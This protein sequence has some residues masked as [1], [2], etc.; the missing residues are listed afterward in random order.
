MFGVQLDSDGK[1]LTLA[2][3]RY[4][5]RCPDIQH[6]FVCFYLRSDGKKKFSL[7]FM[8]PRLTMHTSLHMRTQDTV[9]GV[10]HW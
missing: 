4:R 7:S 10:P 5:D 3:E 6:V 1:V 9:E 2:C 8:P